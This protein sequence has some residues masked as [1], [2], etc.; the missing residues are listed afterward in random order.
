MVS[1]ALK[2]AIKEIFENN[3]GLSVQK[4]WREGEEQEMQRQLQSILCYTY[5]K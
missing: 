4:H 1:H 3:F 2:A 5:T